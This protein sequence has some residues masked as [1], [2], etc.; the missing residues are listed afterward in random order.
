MIALAVVALLVSLAITFAV[1]HGTGG[2]NAP[3]HSPPVR[4]LPV[5]P[6][7]IDNLERAPKMKPLRSAAGGPAG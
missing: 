3:D 5:A 6:V 4:P 2:D 1:A 7:P